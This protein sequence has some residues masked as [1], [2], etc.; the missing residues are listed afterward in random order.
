MDI[1]DEFRVASRLRK[2]YG[3]SARERLGVEVM[4]WHHLH[5]LAC[6]GLE[7]PVVSQT[8][9]GRRCLRAGDGWRV[10]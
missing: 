3:Q 10:T 1:R 2:K 5:D 4:W 7:T 8:G 9:G 6:K